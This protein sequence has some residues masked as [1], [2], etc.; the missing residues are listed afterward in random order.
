VW[1][2][3]AFYCNVTDQRFLDEAPEQAVQVGFVSSP[4]GAPASSWPM[5]GFDRLH[6]V[7]IVPTSHGQLGRATLM[8]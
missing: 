3:F 6:G 4:I 1:T 7:T 5:L 8:H 2:P